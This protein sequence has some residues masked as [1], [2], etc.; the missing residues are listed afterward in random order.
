[1]TLPTNLP[2]SP[3]LLIAAA[4][5]AFGI[6]FFLLG[7]G[8]LLALEDVIFGVWEWLF[9]TLRPGAHRLRELAREA[10]S[11]KLVQ[12]QY[13]KNFV[14]VT[15][16]AVFRYPFPILVAAG[17]AVWV[18]DWML[19]PIIVVIGAVVSA[20]MFSRV[21]RRFYNQLTDELE[22]LILQFVSRYPLRNSV[23]TALAEAADQLPGGLLR[24]SAASTATR[25]KLQDS[26]NPFRD[27]IAVPHPVARRFAGV[28]MR[29]GFAA[30]EVFLDLL[31]QLRKDTESRRELQQRVRRDLTLESATITILQVVLIASLVAVVL[32]PSWRTYYIGTVGNRML[33]I[34]LVALGIIGTVIGE[35][36][37]RY[38][39][40]A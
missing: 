19:S 3:Y 15:F 35:N 10:R 7:R 14:T 26:G 4:A 38:L 30:P 16:L 20:A 37:V 24:D 28:L 33:Y 27:L 29:A 1:M 5:A 23:A 8:I 21:S 22:M 32:I 17:L 39:E 2:F 18:R 12:T 6:G 25:L 11:P 31:D 36:E 13:G 40:E 9:R 34:L